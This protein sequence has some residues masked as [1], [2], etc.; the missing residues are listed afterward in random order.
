MLVKFKLGTGRTHQIRVHSKF[1]GHPV[2]GDPLYNGKKEFGLESQLLHA[3]RLELDHPSTGERMV[4]C[5][6]LPDTFRKTLKKLRSV[7]H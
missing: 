5:A 3:Y 6:P 4:F 7:Y 2:V 1:I